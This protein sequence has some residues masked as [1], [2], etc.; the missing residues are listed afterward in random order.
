VILGLL[1]TWTI[2]AATGWKTQIPALSVLVAFSFSVVIGVI[3]GYY[4]AKNAG[5][6]D[7]IE[8]LRYE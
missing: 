6:M 1:L 3:F 5:Q 8:A 7:P 2:A 4:P